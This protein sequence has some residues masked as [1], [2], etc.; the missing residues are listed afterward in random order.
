M[1]RFEDLGYCPCN[2]IIHTQEK[3]WRDELTQDEKGYRRCLWQLVGANLVCKAPENIPYTVETG[4]LFFGTK[5]LADL[6]LSAIVKRYDF[7]ANRP[8]WIIQCRKPDSSDIP[9]AEYFLSVK[10]KTPELI[11]SS[12][13]AGK[14]VIISDGDAEGELVVAFWN[15]TLELS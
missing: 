7:K 3:V 4:K 9:V 8:I 14:I 10:D 15:T 13:D 12:C 6:V 11:F 5:D 1:A 2:E